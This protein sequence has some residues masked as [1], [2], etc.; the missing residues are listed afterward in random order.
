[1]NRTEILS[2]LF[3]F[4]TLILLVIFSQIILLK[5]I[6]GQGLTNE[7]YVG[8]FEARLYKDQIFTDPINT[9]KEIGLHNAT[10]TF[11]MYF[12]D[13]LF[14][15][16]YTMYLY[17]S[18][19]LKI[20]AALLL[21]PLILILTKNKLLSFLGTLLYAISYPSAGALYLY[22]VG[23][24]YL[25]AAFLNLFLI[26]YYY[27]VKKT[28]YI[29]LF[30]SSFIIVLAF[31]SA[32][33]RIFPVFLIILTIELYLLIKSKFSQLLS[34]ILRITAIFLPIAIITLLS[35]GAYGGDAY[36]LVGWPDFLKKIMDGNWY[37]TLYPLWGLGYTFL[38]VAHFHILGKIDVSNLSSFLGSLLQTPLIIFSI[39]SSLLAFFIAQKRMRFFFILISVNLLLDIVLFFLS[40]HHFSI[41][42]NLVREYSGIPFLAGLYSNILANYII[43]V[44][45]TSLIEWYLTGR[46]NKLLFWIFILP[47][48]S[49]LF[50]VGQWIFTRDYYMYQ[51]G[52][53]RYFVI[54]AI[55]SYL[56]IASLMVMIYQRKKA[57]PRFFAGLVII[58]LLFLIFNISKNEIAQLFYGKKGSGKNLQLQQSMKDQALSY[59]PKDKIKDD[60]LIYFKFASN[61][62]N[63]NQWEDTFD[64]RNLTFWMHIKRSYLTNNSIDGCIAMT[65][66]YSELQKMAKIQDGSKGF[67]YKDEGNKEMRCFHNG[68][69]YSLDGKLVKLDDFYA[70]A[71]E[72]PKVINITEEVKKGLLFNS[73]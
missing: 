11:Y 68:I 70:F 37:L 21:Y 1:M 36:N 27:C 31:L 53:H 47:F 33:I 23:N 24:E 50:I 64:W 72:G 55:G 4:L 7:D 42:Q 8:L 71:V 3:I 69:G 28:T 40:T 41:P 43:S 44:S 2:H 10:H 35:L 38:P 6:V 5:P 65:W 49:L 58:F 32:P 13:V 54:P 61:K 22:V 17:S 63:A 46:N 59:I 34:S 56:F 67:L 51:E 14:G 9:W 19:F 15:E 62:G 20:V 45:F 29:T 30:L 39:A 18:I 52:I 26:S 57:S 48:L 66:D 12:L 16:N 60:L 25:G 73:L